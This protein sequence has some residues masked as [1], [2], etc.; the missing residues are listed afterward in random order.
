RARAVLDEKHRELARHEGERELVVRQAGQVRDNLET[1]TFELQELEKQG[2][3]PERK[4]TMI[5]EMDGCQARRAE[6][7]PGVE[8]RNRALQAL[9]QDHKRSLNEVMAANVR[10]A[11]QRQ[12]LEHLTEQREPLGERIAQAEAMIKE[13]A[14]RVEEYRATI[15]G[16]KRTVAEQQHS[17]P[18]LETLRKT[19]QERLLAL[20]E[21]REQQQVEFKALDE[22]L[23][24]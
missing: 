14:A 1:V 22:R 12:E 4:S 23:K 10:V 6:I 21:K 19:Q 15:E 16:L 13:R 24:Q 3:S 20:Q 7:K 9:E 2:S 11:Q 5:A 17:I 8:T 18:E